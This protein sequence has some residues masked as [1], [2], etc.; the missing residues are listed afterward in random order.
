MTASLSHS[1]RPN[2]GNCTRSLRLTAGRQARSNAEDAALHQQS[3]PC[4][5][6]Q[7]VTVTKDDGIVPSMSVTWRRFETLM[8]S[9][10][11][12]KM[13]LQPTDDTERKRETGFAMLA[14]VFRSAT[15]PGYQ[16]PELEDWMPRTDAVVSR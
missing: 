6:G 1:R 11:S 2:G 5:V 13:P 8:T 10:S 3:T 14:A 16:P 7:W 15:R 4:T 12:K 9:W